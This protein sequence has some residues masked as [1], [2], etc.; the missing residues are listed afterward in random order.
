MLNLWF[1]KFINKPKT[2]NKKLNIHSKIN[3]KCIYLIL[4]HKV[5]CNKNNS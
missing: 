1:K 3:L 5:F 2:I 4:T